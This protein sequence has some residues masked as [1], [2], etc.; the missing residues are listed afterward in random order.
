[1]GREFVESGAEGAPVG[2]M[3]PDDGPEG[4][5]VVL[6]GQVRQFVHDDIFYA[7][8]GNFRQMLVEADETFAGG[9]TSPAALH[10]TAV[11]RK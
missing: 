3:P 7:F 9:A 6:D 2:N 10:A 8:D 5:G 4:R 11:C 1:M